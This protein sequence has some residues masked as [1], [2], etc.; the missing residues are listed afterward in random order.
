[1]ANGSKLV[2]SGSVKGIRVRVAV[3]KPVKCMLRFLT[4]TRTV[5]RHPY[6]VTLK[7]QTS[8]EADSLSP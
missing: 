2:G 3:K 4:L 8:L 6:S 1:M 7:R 5:R